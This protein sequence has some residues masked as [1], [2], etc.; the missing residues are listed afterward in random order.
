MALAPALS[1]VLPR[2][3]QHVRIISRD[4]T[5]DYGRLAV[6]MTRVLSPSPASLPSTVIDGVE[7]RRA[8]QEPSGVKRT[9][10]IFASDRLE[11]E[12][13]V[14][15]RTILR[16]ALQIDCRQTLR[17]V[18][19]FGS[20]GI[21]MYEGAV[22]RFRL[23][24]SRLPVARRTRARH[25]CPRRPASTSRAIPHTASSTTSCRITSR[26]FARRRPRCGTGKACPGLSSG[27]F[28]SSL[29]AGVSRRDSRGSS[30]TRAV[31]IG[32][33]RSQARGAAFVPV[34][35]VAAWPNARRIP[36]PRI[37]LVLYYGL[38]APRAPWRAAVVASAGSE[39][40]DAAAA[41]G[42]VTDE[43]NDCAGRRR[44]R[45]YLWAELMRRTFGIDVLDCPRCGGRLRLLALI[46][47]ARIVDR[48][49]RSGT[50]CA[51]TR[52]GG[53]SRSS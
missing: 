31:T 38:L 49:L 18:R 52:S 11:R 10:V 29:R 8:H 39:W 16:D 21:A 48:I 14:D 25:P 32:S 26:R 44:P 40:S 3:G 20:A 34:A 9:A 37:N 6:S 45:G 13:V 43:E 35:A 24:S 50:F 12:A 2:A 15:E 51:T 36:R 1:L 27:S 30:A 41:V 5:I 53:C 23:H 28:A 46:E 7:Q 33:C 47:H 19:A 17:S 4:V 22:P 42:P